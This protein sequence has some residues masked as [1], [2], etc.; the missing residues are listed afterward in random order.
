MII[1]NFNVHSFYDLFYILCYIISCK[2]SWALA[3][4]ARERRVKIFMQ[5]NK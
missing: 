2:L 5:K 3:I 1:V 4:L